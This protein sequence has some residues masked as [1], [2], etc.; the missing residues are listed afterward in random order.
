MFISN[1]DNNEIINTDNLTSITY[2]DGSTSIFF[3]FNAMSEQEM[4]D[5]EWRFETRKLAKNT[6]TNITGLLSVFYI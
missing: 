1:K 5:V 4:N 3:Q 6:H 2:K